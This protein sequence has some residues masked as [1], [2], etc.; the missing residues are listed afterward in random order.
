MREQGKLDRNVIED[1]R[2]P[3]LFK[4]AEVRIPEWKQTQRLRD[5]RT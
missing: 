5:I 1:N 4:G 3:D 2:R